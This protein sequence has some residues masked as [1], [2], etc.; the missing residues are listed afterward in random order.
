MTHAI[1]SAALARKAR[2]LL[3]WYISDH[4]LAVEVDTDGEPCNCPIC[5]KARRFVASLVAP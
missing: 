3:L 1:T 5:K 4:D 2:E